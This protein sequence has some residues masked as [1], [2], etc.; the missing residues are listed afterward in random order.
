MADITF[1]GF[2]SSKMLQAAA[3]WEAKTENELLNNRVIAINEVET[4]KMSNTELV[5][6][7]IK[8]IN[9][10]RPGYNKNVIINILTCVAQAF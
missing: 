6:Y 8:T 2:M 3:G 9:I 5:D 4:E 1:D 7:L 10:A